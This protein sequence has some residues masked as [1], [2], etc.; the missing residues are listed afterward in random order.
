MLKDIKFIIIM[1]LFSYHISYLAFPLKN[2][3]FN[4]SSTDTPKELIQKLYYSNLHIL[5][6]IGSQKV[7]T[8][9]YL[10]L[11]RAELMISGK[12][13]E[14]HKYNESNSESYNCSNCNNIVF[15]GAYSHGIIS[16][17]IFNVKNNKNETITIHN[18]NFILGK[19]AREKNPPEGIVGLHLPYYDSYP[20][21][22]L[23]VSLKKAKATNSYY[24]FLDYDNHQN[25]ESK[26]IIDG[27]PHDLNS[28]K[29]DP[30]K[31]VTTNAIEGG[32]G[33]YVIWGLKFS[34]IYYNNNNNSQTS[35]SLE[36]H[37][38]AHIL[39]NYEFIIAPNETRVILENIFFGEYIKKNICFKDNLGNFKETFFYCKNVKEFE[40]KKFK[41]IF[42]KSVDLLTIFELNYNDLFYYKDDY[43]YFLILF[44]GSSWTFG[45]IFLKKYYLVFNQDSKTIGYYMNI[46]DE[47][48]INS[49]DSDNEN[50]AKINLIYI[51]LIL[52]LVS[53]IIVGIIL[54]TKK[55]KRKSRANELD[56]D[57]EYDSKI[58]D[59]DNESN[60]I[61]ESN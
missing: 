28:T 20:D 38:T 1:S 44:K 40:I 60:K 19:K 13:I 25:F 9:A 7:N 35:I 46:E 26:M 6:N 58:N 8:K 16:N 42:F 2:D 23:I 41:T 3:D 18:M 15:S 21:Y 10:V 57:Y 56:D 53:I 59:S 45:E 36:S 30:E 4:L 14:N 24:W 5:I 39:F 34:N 47:R 29:Y 27:F 12:D 37:R 22:N 61:I 52:I 51:L 17:E 31:V 43:I 49:D 50:K 48:P 54:F 11:T 32:G 33:Y 55:G